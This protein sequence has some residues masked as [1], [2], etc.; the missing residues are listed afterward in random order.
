MR[1]RCGQIGVEAREAIGLYVAV[2]G[3]AG[4]IATDNAIRGQTGV[5][6]PTRWPTAT[7]PTQVGWGT[8]RD[9]AERDRRAAILLR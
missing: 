6:A 2:R 3:Q 1:R 8:E 9:A 7:K 4:A 5:E